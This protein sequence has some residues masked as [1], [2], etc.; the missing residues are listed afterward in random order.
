[1]TPEVY[2]EYFGRLTVDGLE[3]WG[4]WWNISSVWC[5]SARTRWPEI[6]QCRWCLRQPPAHP[7]EGRH[8]LFLHSEHLV[9]PC[10]GSDLLC[11]GLQSPLPRVQRAC[12]PWLSMGTAGVLASPA[13]HTGCLSA[14]SPP[15]SPSC[16][17]ASLRCS[18]S[19]R[20]ARPWP[21]GVIPPPPPL[22]FLTQ[23]LVL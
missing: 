8:P 7:E 11:P 12:C 1:M 23:F 6:R 22:V 14:H 4:E 9:P 16:C 3:D 21:S 18:C 19:E 15:W 10:L 17:T 20:L 2:R 5:C 13:A